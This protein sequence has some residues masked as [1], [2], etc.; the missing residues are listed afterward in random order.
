MNN[1][2]IYES[3][4]V[5]AQAAR[6]TYPGCFS[7]LC[8]MLVLLGTLVDPAC[9]HSADYFV[10]N[11]K[12]SDANGG[13]ISAPWAT[14]TKAGKSVKPGDT[15]FILSNG[16]ARPY[17]ETFRIKASGVPGRYI[18][19]KGSS[20]SHRPT[21]TGD[22]GESLLSCYDGA[23]LKIEDLSFQDTT[24][25]GLDFSNCHHI[26]ISNIELKNIGQNG[27]LISGGSN[28]TI[29]SSSISHI[30]NSGIA[31]IGS[32]AGSLSN[33]V[34]QDCQISNVRHNDGITLHKNATGADVGRN[35]I[36][37]NNLLVSCR[38]QGIDVTSGQDILIEKNTT[39]GNGDSG[40]LIGHGA[41]NITIRS[42]RSIDERKYGIIAGD[43]WNVAI[44]ESKI[45]N[46]G[47]NSA[48]RLFRCEQVS[49]SH[50]L[51]QHGPER[52]EG[53]LVDIEPDCR[54]LSF[55]NNTFIVPGGFQGILVRYLPSADPSN[56]RSVWTNNRWVLPSQRRAFFF[57][58]T[59]GKIDFRRYQKR[60]APT[61][62][63]AGT[64]QSVQEVR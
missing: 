5:D 45:I 13:D 19:F 1:R 29:S 20:P 22:G 56:T 10:D 2:K 32:T 39:S 64:P 44:T 34:I 12:G 27:I 16:A 50:N 38:E 47:S 31:L 46:P 35:H 25:T 63:F 3:G 52:T 15:V 41:M 9:I 61:D 26:D 14:L 62:S 37:R 43:S 58:Q 57:S 18:T 21:L 60:Y 51:I 6:E 7:F 28:Y 54:D 36:I 59:D 48:F 55:K 17:N 24:G 40:V 4:P 23:Y 49:I 30:S 53:S 8:S 42:H 11:M 33:T